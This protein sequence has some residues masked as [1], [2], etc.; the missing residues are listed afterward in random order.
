MERVG[1]FLAVCSYGCLVRVSS[2]IML[3]AAAM[4]INWE[5]GL[6]MLACVPFI[7]LSVAALSMLMSSSSTEGTDHYG[8][9]GGVATEVSWKT[10]GSLGRGRLIPCTLLYLQSNRFDVC[11]NVGKS[12]A[13]FFSFPLLCVLTCLVGSLFPSCWFLICSFA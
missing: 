11:R 4:Y 5:L 2:G 9:A 6:V 1:W 8:K 10:T 3:L 13:A 7:G 12:R